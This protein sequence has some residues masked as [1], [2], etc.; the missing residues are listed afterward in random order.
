MTLIFRIR[1]RFRSR[2]GLRSK[3]RFGFG[4]RSGTESGLGLVFGLGLECALK[5]R[6]GSFLGFAKLLVLVEPN[7]TQ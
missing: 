1:F 6:R 3:L 2:F 4:F 7:Y 5:A